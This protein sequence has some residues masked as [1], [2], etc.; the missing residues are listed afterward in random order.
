MHAY[1]WGPKGVDFSRAGRLQV[2][3]LDPFRVRSGVWSSLPSPSPWADPAQVAE[4]FGY[5]RSSPPAW[6]IT[7]D[8]SGRAGVLS[9]T[10]RGATELFAVEENRALLPLGNAT[11]QGMGT[12]F[13]AVRLGATYYVLAQEEQSSLRLF[14]LDSGQARLVGQYADVA[15]GARGLSSAL[16]RSVR[17]DALGIWT[18]GAGWFVFPVDARSGAVGSAIEVSASELSRL[19]RSCAPDEEGYLLEGPVGLDPY[20][21]FPGDDPARKTS[22]RSFEGRFIVSEHGICV[23]ALAARSERPVQRG[24]PPRPNERPANPRVSLT[25]QDYAEGGRRWGFR[26]GD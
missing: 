9:V 26:C 5:E 2:S 23:S 24:A 4:V 20:A 6:Q 14:M 3:V 11:R 18:R 15:Q 8:P 21:E 10:A 19:P 1:T 7:L 13:S 12:V 17:G 25:I 22:A 16:V